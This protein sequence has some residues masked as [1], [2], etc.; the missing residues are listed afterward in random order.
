MTSKTRSPRTE[1]EGPRPEVEGQGVRTEVQHQTQG[2]RKSRGRDPVLVSLEGPIT[3]IGVDGKNRSTL[4]YDRRSRDPVGLP[5]TTKIPSG[6]KRKTGT[7]LGFGQETSVH[8]STND[9]WGTGLG[10]QKCQVY[11]CKY[12]GREGLG[13]S[14]WFLHLPRGTSTRQGL[15]HE[16]DS[17]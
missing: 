2:P 3:P 1:V 17:T 16:S 10:C 7:R 13:W 5:T 14:G 6:G 15:G 4:K 11:L 9:S 8:D 12:K